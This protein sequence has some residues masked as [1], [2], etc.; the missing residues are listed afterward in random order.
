MA[1][2]ASIPI[3]VALIASM[4]R[5]ATPLI[6][7][8]LGGV[9]SER[10]GVVNIGLE[11]MMIMGAFFAVYG[12]YKTG[13]PWMGLV[14]AIVAGGFIA[15]IHAFLSISLKADQTISGTAI[16]LFAA[17][18]TS[19]L[20]VELFGRKGQTDGVTALPYPREMLSKI[21]V[22]GKLLGELNWFVFIAIILVAVITFILFKTPL[23]LRIRAVGEHPKAADTLGINVYAVRYGCV[24]ASGM[25]AALGGAS[26]S[27]G[28]LN[29][30]SEGMINGRGF[31]AMAAVIFGNWK[32]VGAF[33]ACLLFAFADAFQILAQ[34]FAWNIPNDVYYAMPY[35]LTL[36]VIAGFVGKSQAPAADGVPY[37]KNSR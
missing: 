26:L 2:T 5:M 23:G 8:A 24:I 9:I 25:L 18:L 11:G 6:F 32:P 21:P 15:F 22:I 12:S 20:I 10:S 13:S 19:Y 16:N 33:G 1:N 27:I 36:I 4:L 14:F 30:F 31:I 7:T 28:S 34:R 29:L 37:E 17:A 3:V 35:I